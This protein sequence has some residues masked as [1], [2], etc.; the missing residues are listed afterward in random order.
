MVGPAKHEPEAGD[1]SA[2]IAKLELRIR[3]L[4]QEGRSARTRTEAIV[5]E[6]DA[7]RRQVALLDQ[8]RAQAEAELRERQGT[9]AGRGVTTERAQLAHAKATAATLELQLKD[10]TDQREFDRRRI[11]AQSDERRR[12]TQRAAE[13]GGRA[14]ELEA[15]LA[16]EQDNLADV[17]DRLAA[18]R[19]ELDAATRELTRHGAT[20]RERDDALAELGANERRLEQQ[21]VQLQELE[22]QL[23]R[24]EAELTAVRTHAEE[25]R[26]TIGELRERAEAAEQPLAAS[27][28]ERRSLVAHLARV[29]SE[30]VERDE[31][32]DKLVSSRWYQ[33]ASATWRLRRRPV[34]LAIG[35]GPALLLVA[36]FAALAL[37]DAPW[38]AFAGLAAVTVIVLGLI[39]RR[40]LRG[41]RRRP[42]RRRRSAAVALAEGQ[43]IAPPP[44]APA[45][46]T[47]AS[48]QSKPD[49][50]PPNAGATLPAPGAGA[51][52]GRQVGAVPKLVPAPSADA[53]I[54]TDREAFL[55]GGRHLA[56]RELR[57]A[58]VLDE[59]SRACFAPECQLFCEFT[60]KD[61]EERLSAWHPHLLLVES[62][63]S[64]NSGGW[65]YGVASY[66]HPHYA[67]L[68]SL[69]ALLQ[70][71]RQREIPTV[72]WNK[73][74][75]VHFDRF[76]EA[77]ALFDH[78]LTTDSNCIP[79]YEALDG[80]HVRSV[81]ALPFA[82]QPRLHNPIAIVD[83]RRPEPVFAGAYYRTRHDDRRESLEMILD[84]ARPFG[85]VIYDRTHGTDGEE[86]G[87]PE[88]FA[89]HISG[90]L[91]YDQMI[92]VYK[93]HRVFLNVNSV[94]DSPTM[95]S[96][97][98]FELLACGTAVVSTE[99]VGMEEMFGD[100]VAVVRSPEE[101][102]AAIERLLRD[103]GHFAEVTRRA[104]RLVLSQHTYRQRLAQVAQT[105]GFDVTPDAGREVTAIIV[106]DGRAA[107]SPTAEAVLSQTAAPEE[108]IIATSSPA[109][110]QPEVDRLT[111]RWGAGRIRV[112]TQ[113]ADQPIEDRYR[114]LGRLAGTPWVAPMGDGAMYTA[115]HLRDLAACTDFADA[116][117]IGTAPIG[118]AA[119]PVA[120]RYVDALQPLTAL[121]AREVVATHGWAN[122]PEAV[123]RLFDRGVRF[124]AG[125][126]SALTWSN[127]P[128][129][130]GGNGSTGRHADRR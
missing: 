91:P 23:S 6:R 117:A 48:S 123:R 72:F 96:R 78:V 2:G 95:F 1:S 102:T 21:R 79:A 81:S 116:Q 107:L 70:W 32:V 84:A 99:S 69:K 58:G 31:R 127:A 109:E 88:R 15:R 62:A 18:L 42:R 80:E 97:R 89:P 53:A 93:R 101:A 24:R 92:D 56:P 39:G 114:E 66:S 73:E 124:Y 106:A 111:E 77:A 86:F 30:L 49:S 76:K 8:A 19:D 14:I 33:L 38:P 57:I 37:L 94:I 105:V 61:W 112:C 35:L 4:E 67:G 103:D 51:A 129:D 52:L 36:A 47:R 85:L 3:Q 59:M 130:V 82:A 12:L 22:A 68:P 87:F 90:R 29:E 126:G 65:Q 118:G 44:G 83:Q 63:W 5:L 55:I 17:N 10:L 9:D 120:H 26:G 45:A 41:L 108:V 28:E 104:R 122:E 64:G 74:D 75:P 119:Q 60:I 27:L 113:D 25:L 110:L 20:Q 115:D 7:L 125:D 13:A 121:V 11:A 40:A 100:L 128:A 16:A 46:P 50:P 71:C 98:V 34:L 54:D 43:E